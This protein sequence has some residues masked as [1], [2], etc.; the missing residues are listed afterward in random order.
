[1]AKRK[2]DL[3]CI[4]PLIIANDSSLAKKALPGITVTVSL[5][6]IKQ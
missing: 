6:K 5:P 1:M 3:L 2:K 4:Y